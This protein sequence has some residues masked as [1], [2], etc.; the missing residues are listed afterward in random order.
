[1]STSIREFI[2]GWMFLSSAK[3]S[4]NITRMHECPTPV[5]DFTY[6]RFFLPQNP[7]T[8]FHECTNTP[9]PIRA[10]LRRTAFVA[11]QVFVV[12]LIRGWL[13]RS[14]P[15]F[16]AVDNPS[17]NITR[18]LEYLTPIREHLHRT[19]VQVFVVGLIRGWPFQS[20]PAFPA[21]TA[22]RAISGVCK[23]RRRGGTWIMPLQDY[24]FV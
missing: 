9:T 23:S 14:S 16:L 3:P 21:R 15:G 18:I 11:V 6:G 24:G 10:H 20:P 1:M 17:T 12:G 5:R 22:N 8:N 2:F 4:T 19:Q 7:S 13:F